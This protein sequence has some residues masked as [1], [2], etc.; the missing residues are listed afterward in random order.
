MNNEFDVIVVGSGPAGATV[1]RELSKRGRRVLIVERGGNPPLGE[2]FLRTASLLN[3]VSVGS[4][5]TT[6]RAL[7]TGGTSSVYFAVAH[8]PPLELFRSLGIELSGAVEDVKRELP[9]T[10]LPDA[11]VGAQTK[12]ARESA[13]AL[14]YPWVKRTM[15]VDLAKCPSGYTYDSKWT[16]RAYV[17]EALAHGATLIHGARVTKVLVEKNEAVGVE[18]MVGKASE[19]RR[20]YGA[21]VVVAAGAVATPVLLRN[22]GVRNIADRGFCCHPTMVVLGNVPGM[23]AGDTFSGCEGA[24]LEDD[25]SVGDANAS[26]TIHRLF[27]IGHRRLLRAFM[28]RRSVALGIMIRDGMGGALGEDNRYHKELSQDDRLRLRKG[29]QIARRILEHAGARNVIAL[30]IG[31]GHVGGTVR[32][33]EHVDQNLETEYR[34][35]HVCDGS[36]IPETVKISPTL[37][38]ICLG[39]YLATRLSPAV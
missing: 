21:K 6:V 10:E 8:F 34:N 32:I 3:G 26:S 28:H 2:S 38:L 19:P 23:K 14:G 24:D 29:E 18:Y 9:L 39:K 1:A 37:P 17:D 30:P 13:L 22:S 4:K 7:T 27:M 36:V 31:A 12:R 11:I 20:A 5:L 25:I 35:L 33:G 16:A 15:L